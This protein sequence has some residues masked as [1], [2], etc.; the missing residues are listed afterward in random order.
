MKKEC[1]TRCEWHLKLFNS[2]LFDFPLLFYFIPWYCIWFWILGN[3][4]LALCITNNSDRIAPEN[5]C[6]EFLTTVLQQALA[7]MDFPEVVPMTSFLGPRYLHETKNISTFTMYKAVSICPLFYYA[8]FCLAEIQIWGSF[9]D[10]IPVSVWQFSSY[11]SLIYI[12]S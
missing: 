4:V 3:S 11:L 5:C 8:L 12:Y 2:I 9:G 10:E 7:T 6:H 1:N